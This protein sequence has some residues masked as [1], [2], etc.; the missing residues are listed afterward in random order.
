MLPSTKPMTARVR[1]DAE[2][3]APPAL[4]PRQRDDAAH[5]AGN[6]EGQTDERRTANQSQVAGRQGPAA[7]VDRHQKLQAFTFVRPPARRP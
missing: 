7:D 6:G 2:A 4:A 1:L 3:A 5:D